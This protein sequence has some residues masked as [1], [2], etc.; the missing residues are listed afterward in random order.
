MFGNFCK[1]HHLVLKSLR[2]QLYLSYLMSLKYLL[3]LKILMILKCHLVL[4]NLR[5]Q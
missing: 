1:Y 2:Y 5:Y 4:K 3:Y